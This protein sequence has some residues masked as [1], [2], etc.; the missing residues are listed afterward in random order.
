MNTRR[1]KSL[2]VRLLGALAAAVFAGKAAADD[3]RTEV[4]TGNRLLRDGKVDEA[5]EHYRKAQ[6]LDPAHPETAFNIGVA[7]CGKE[8][9]ESAE[10][11]LSKVLEAD[12]PDLQSRAHYN[13]GIAQFEQS[14]D[15]SRSE[16]IVRLRNA[17]THFRRSMELDPEDRDAK[18]NYEIAQRG[19]AKAMEEEEK[20]EDFEPERAPEPEDEGKPQELDLSEADREI[21]E[22]IR[23]VLE[24]QSKGDRGLVPGRELK[25]VATGIGEEEGESEA[26]ELKDW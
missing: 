22:K 17:L 26:G 14:R 25:G 24:G 4:A 11:A 12:R 7:L 5:L 21:E 13:L 3:A 8:S 2:A 6:E 1:Q 20:P 16:K 19:L 23:S 18:Y 15:A 10:K 9:W